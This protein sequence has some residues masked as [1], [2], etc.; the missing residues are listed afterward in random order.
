MNINCL[1]L[2]PCCPARRRARKEAPATQAAGRA[3][4]PIPGGATDLAARPPGAQALL[5][6]LGRK[7]HLLRLLAEQLLPPPIAA[8]AP[9]V[10]LGI[11]LGSLRTVEDVRRVLSMAWR[12]LRAATSHPTR[13]RI[14]Q[15]GRRSGCARPGA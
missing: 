7:L 2:I 11:D 6:L 8:I 5:D 10:R 12:P 14:S 13:P 15:S 9:G 3:A 4:S 1:I